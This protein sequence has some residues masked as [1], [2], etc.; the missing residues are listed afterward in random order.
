MVA[1]TENALL[2]AAFNGDDAV[3]DAIMADSSDWTRSI[4]CRLTV[5]DPGVVDSLDTETVNAGIGPNAWPALLY[6]LNSRYRTRDGTN[7]SGRLDIAKALLGLGA[8][9]DSGTRESETIRGYRTALGAAIGRARNPD[10]AK[11]L[12][13]ARADIAD[14]PTLYEGSAMWEAVRHRDL[15]SLEILLGY[16]P[17]PWH[18]C[19]ALP[20]CLALNDLDFVRLLLYHD[21]DPNWTM[22]TW[23]F[24]GNCLHE[25][26]VLGN[27]PGIVEALL[28]KGAD[29]HFRDR[30]G[31][32]P[33]AVAICLNRDTHLALLRRSGAKEDD[34][35]P[36]DRW[37]SACFAGDE[38]RA[39]RGQDPS[40]L[41]P[42]DHVWLCRAVRT[43]N[44]DAVRLL[45]AGGIDP[46][47]VDDDGNQALHLAAG[48]GNALAAERLIDAGAD[49]QAVNYAGETPFDMAHRRSNAS[50]DAVSAL[51]A[52]HRP[53]Q[54]SVLYDDPD[55]AAVFERAADAVVD[56][57][58]V[59]LDRL[60]R[61]NPV[62]ANARSSRPHRCT[63]LHYLGANG[64]EGHRQK[65]PANAVEAID[66]LLAA[67]ADPNASCYTY[68]GGPD[69][70]TVGL[71]TSSGHPR[72]AGL[73][74]SMVSALAKG[75][76][77]VSDVYR[78]LGE[79][80]D[81]DPQQVAGFNPE[82]DIA[83]QAVVECAGLRERR[84][85]FALI[86]AG[87][88]VSARRGDGATAL[89]QAAIDGDRELVE[90]LLERGADLSLRDHTYDGTAAGWA[91][92]GGHE[93]LGRA[94]AERMGRRGADPQGANE[95]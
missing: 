2:D 32:S 72:D 56:G 85:L 46:D 36:V 34:I 41:T 80:V 66:T 11:L 20:H 43:G 24:K 62:L 90:A 79:L 60:L 6:L 31:R 93:E 21:A 81:R 53:R 95:P 84:M 76:A 89:H 13:E 73:T 7:P 48:A 39:D 45:L 9:P 25:A 26:V 17:P 22:G 1:S 74:V 35:R 57:D 54:P 4:P 65:T 28:G 8:D 59:T 27:V 91:F 68:R 37:V 92:A 30:G 82:S 78:L 61:A 55:F 71:L 40:G 58:V 88:D 16:D 19:H 29:V 51:L 94:L 5:A 86:D 3:A 44:N 23:G 33:L 47:A 75:G 87:V 14:G 15:E 83:A 12:L 50:P 64:V 42:I 38:S 18:A 52:P 10:L 77:R 70:T 63:L 67:G 69:E 49:T